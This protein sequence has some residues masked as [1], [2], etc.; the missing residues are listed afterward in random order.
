MFYFHP[1]LQKIPILTNLF[2]W[3]ETTQ[4]ANLSY[5]WMCFHERLSLRRKMA[6]L[7]WAKQKIAEVMH[8][9][10]YFFFNQWFFQV[11]SSLVLFSKVSTNP[12][13]KKQLGKMQ[14]RCDEDMF[15]KHGSF[16]FNFNN[17][18]ST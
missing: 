13:N 5:L 10:R 7:G 15:F 6:P 12:W 1:Y 9:Q 8:L 3:V 14:H 4:Q 16:K 18:N 2:K 17:K 11:C